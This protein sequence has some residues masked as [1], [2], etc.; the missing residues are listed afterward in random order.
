MLHVAPGTY[1]PEN[2]NFVRQPSFTFGSRPEQKV[3]NDTPAPSAY[4]TEKVNLSYQPAFSFG[5]RQEDK[6]K[7]DSPGK[8]TRCF[9][10]YRFTS[11]LANI[12]ICVACVKL[13]VHIH[14]RNIIQNSSCLIHSAYALSK[15]ITMIHLVSRSF[16]LSTSIST[17]T[18]AC[19]ELI[20]MF[21]F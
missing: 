11:N 3:R 17:N 13:L 7:S 15:K 1:S 2:S 12:L 21:A 5:S 6:I 16:V 19:I 8:C 14:R 9:A 10:F 20:A 18:I 4:A